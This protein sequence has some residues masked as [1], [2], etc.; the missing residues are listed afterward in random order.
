MAQITHNILTGESTSISD[1]SEEE[2]RTALSRIVYINVSK[3]PASKTS[4]S[5]DLSQKYELWR[6][7]LFMQI[8][9]YSPDIIIFGY[10]FGLFSDDLG[11]TGDF[12]YKDKDGWT[13]I[14]KKDGRLLVDT[15]HPANTQS[16]EYFDYPT[17]VV[18][19]IQKMWK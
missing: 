14:Y 5:S 9:L 12:D 3:I 8:D 10:T 4:S 15:Y 6:E 7:T 18:K 13:N 1:L 19:S 17:A 2:I 11:V 16:Y